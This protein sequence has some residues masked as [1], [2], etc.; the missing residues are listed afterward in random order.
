MSSSMIVCSFLLL[1]ETD[2]DDDDYFLTRVFPQAEFR[3]TLTAKVIVITVKLHGA[4]RT[5]RVSEYVRVS[6]FCMTSSSS[7]KSHRYG[8]CLSER[9]TIVYL[10]GN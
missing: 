3:F 10:P 2:D 5:L 7:P 4:E 6:C 1:H 8:K 9:V